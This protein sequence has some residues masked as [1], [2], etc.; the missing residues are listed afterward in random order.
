[1]SRYIPPYPQ[2]SRNSLSSYY[3]PFHKNLLK[4]ALIDKNVQDAGGTG[5]GWFILA[6]RFDPELNVGLYD[7]DQFAQGRLFNIS[8]P[9]DG[10]LHL[11][12]SKKYEGVYGYSVIYQAHFGYQLLDAKRTCAAIVNIDEEHHPTVTQMD[13]MLATV[14]AQPGST[15]LFMGPHAKIYG[16]NPYKHE[17]VQLVNGD[18]NANTRIETWNGISITTSYNIDEKIDHVSV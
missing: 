18:T 2:L 12:K 16:V 11:L 17:N 7:P 14:R 6:T 13:E 15:H 8:Y 3:V 5:K 9:Y 10:A 1:M 4:A